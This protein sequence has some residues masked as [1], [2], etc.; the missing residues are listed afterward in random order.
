M[1]HPR[2]L[3]ILIEADICRQLVLGIPSHED[4]AKTIYRNVFDTL[5]SRLS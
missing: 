5:V 2:R 4:D 1:W 3:F